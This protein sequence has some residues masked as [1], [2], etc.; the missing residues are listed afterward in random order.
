M[1]DQTTASGY[2]SLKALMR[3]YWMARK[4]GKFDKGRLN[5]GL[6]IAMRARTEKVGPERLPEIEEGVP[7]Y[8]TLYRT[9]GHEKVAQVFSIKDCTCSD[10]LTHRFCKHRIAAMLIERAG[11]LDYASQQAIQLLPVVDAVESHSGVSASVVNTGIDTPHGSS[12]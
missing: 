8:T 7:R 1:S 5:R 10:H 2:S 12:L 11:D 3:A 4:S 9:P 6:G